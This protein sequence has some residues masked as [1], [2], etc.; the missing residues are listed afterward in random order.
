MI[1]NNDDDHFVQT[2]TLSYLPATGSTCMTIKAMTKLKKM[3]T[4]VIIKSIYSDINHL[5]LSA[6]IDKN[7]TVRSK[8]GLGLWKMLQKIR[9]YRLF[10]KVIGCS[11]ILRGKKIVQDEIE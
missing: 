11:K 6:V 3:M 1:L 2:L 8:Q 4:K 10:L 5:H 9:F 7:V